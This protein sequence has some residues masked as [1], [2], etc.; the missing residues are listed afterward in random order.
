[1]KKRTKRRYK[2]IRDV[3]IKQTGAL[4]VMT[5]DVVIGK[6]ATANVVQLAKDEWDVL[7]QKPDIVYS[8]RR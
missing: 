3:A 2:K 5:E 4:K 6:V 8:Y 7:S 1:M